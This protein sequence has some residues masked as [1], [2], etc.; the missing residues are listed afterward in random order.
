[1]TISTGYLKSSNAVSRAYAQPKSPTHL[2]KPLR[3]PGKPFALFEPGAESNGSTPFK[4]KDGERLVI[5]AFGLGCDDA[6]ELWKVKMT[7]PAKPCPPECSICPTGEQPKPQERVMEY[8]KPVKHCGEVVQLDSDCS[9]LTIDQPGT[10]QLRVCNT[11]AL[12]R[13]HVEATVTSACCL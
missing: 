10:Y 4:V 7:A 3:V 5:C 2:V 12:C 1:M 8:A 11:D 9:D 6:I 13:I